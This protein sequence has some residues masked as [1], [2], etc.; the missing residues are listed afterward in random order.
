MYV[1][2]ST[3]N[4]LGLWSRASRARLYAYPDLNAAYIVALAR[5][6]SLA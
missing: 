2:I 5:A 3:E 1:G 6:R 4:H